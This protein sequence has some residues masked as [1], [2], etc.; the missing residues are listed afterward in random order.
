MA[1]YSKTPNDHVYT[2]D[3][4]SLSLNQPP[5]HVE[6]LSACPSRG[7]RY[8]ASARPLLSQEPSPPPFRPRTRARAPPPHVGA[9]PLPPRPPVHPPLS[10]RLQIR[11]PEPIVP[12]VPSSSILPLQSLALT[13]CPERVL[14]FLAG[15][16][17]AGHWRRCRHRGRSPPPPQHL[18]G[19]PPPPQEARQ[20]RRGV[21]RWVPASRYCHFP[22]HQRLL[23][24]PSFLLSGPGGRRRRLQARS[25]HRLLVTA[26]GAV[27]AGWGPP[28]SAPAVGLRLR[29]KVGLRRA[30]PRPSRETVSVGPAHGGKAPQ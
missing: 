18:L 25:L 29:A 30:G 21:S 10:A 6:A 13:T 26:A 8:L 9:S 3:T 28:R 24:V 11:V 16:V 27:P 4:A 12:R 22:Q 19:W 15:P 14:T 20:R 5:C 23:P 1:S 17:A 2:T 7:L